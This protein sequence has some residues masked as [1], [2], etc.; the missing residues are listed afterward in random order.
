MS[1]APF[2]P[3]KL[4]IAYRV[5]LRSKYAECL[6]RVSIEWVPAGLIEIWEDDSWTPL[7]QEHQVP[8]GF[9]F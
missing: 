8:D 1:Y 4:I 5:V 2:L 3:R 6:H 7:P 9:S